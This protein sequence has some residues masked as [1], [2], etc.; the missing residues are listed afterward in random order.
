[1]SA[2]PFYGASTL[3]HAHYYG[4]RTADVP[5]R[6]APD[7]R[8]LG[9]GQP[10]RLHAQPGTMIAGNTAIKSSS[11]HAQLAWH[12]AKSLHD[13]TLLPREVQSTCRALAA[14]G[15][16]VDE[17]QVLAPRVTAPTSGPPGVRHAGPAALPHWDPVRR[18]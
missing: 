10:P 3:N 2:V 7:V 17:A 1:M 8:A 5:R 6:C 16:A 13:R 15:R 14:A 12:A 11:P 4:R 18:Y 9:G